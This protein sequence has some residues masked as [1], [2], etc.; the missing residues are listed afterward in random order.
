MNKIL[1]ILIIAKRRWERGDHKELI[2]RLV[3]EP[4]LYAHNVTDDVIDCITAQM[5]SMIPYLLVYAD[6]EYE[7]PYVQYRELAA[8]YGYNIQEIVLC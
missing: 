8:L 1:Y 5:D 3:K 6:A 2:K 7:F 4:T